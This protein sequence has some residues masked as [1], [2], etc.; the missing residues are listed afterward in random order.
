[1]DEFT[2]KDFTRPRFDR[3]RMFGA[4]TPTS[5]RLQVFIAGSVGSIGFHLAAP[6]RDSPPP[7]DPRVPSAWRAMTGH[8][9]G[10]EIR[11]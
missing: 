2:S 8:R 1:V 9:R 7:G 4:P 3:R 5:T 10:K 11:P 6:G